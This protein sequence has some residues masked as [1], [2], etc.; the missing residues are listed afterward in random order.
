M[1]LGD[2]EPTWRGVFLN[3]ELFQEGTRLIR[4]LR[5]RAEHPV[6]WDFFKD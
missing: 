1:D 4:K 5:K 6:Q 2:I 3:L